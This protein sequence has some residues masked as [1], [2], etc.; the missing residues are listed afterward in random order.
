MRINTNCP[1]QVL[2]IEQLS[3]WMFPSSGPDVDSD[4]GLP[5]TTPGPV[6]GSAEC[7]LPIPLT[8][9]YASSSAFDFCFFH[10]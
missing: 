9:C 2:V 6:R 4:S 5:N 3:C 1:L 8:I 7:N 10:N